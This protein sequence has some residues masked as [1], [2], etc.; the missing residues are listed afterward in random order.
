MMLSYHSK[1]SI[2]LAVCFSALNRVQAG[3]C[4]MNYKQCDVSWCGSSKSEC[5]QC[6]GDAFTYLEEGERTD[7][8]ARCK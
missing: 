8:L 4:S 7:C 3:C 1:T 5:E 6:G 2:L